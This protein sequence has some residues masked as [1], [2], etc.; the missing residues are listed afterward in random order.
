MTHYEE[1]MSRK[2]RR[3]KARK[4]RINERVQ[5]VSAVPKTDPNTYQAQRSRRIGGT[6]KM[7]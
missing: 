1:Y 3:Q 2:E 4:K 6:L 5:G 7:Q